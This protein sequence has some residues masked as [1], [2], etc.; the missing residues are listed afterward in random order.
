MKTS[1]G[2][3]LSS[4]EHCRSR[5]MTGPKSGGD[6]RPFCS[7]GMVAPSTRGDSWGHSYLR[8]ANLVSCKNIFRPTRDS[9]KR[10]KRLPADREP[11][12]PHDS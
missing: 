4:A 9:C 12:A 6:S 8:H 2:K 11:L 7:K 5:R 3:S 1:R 10:P